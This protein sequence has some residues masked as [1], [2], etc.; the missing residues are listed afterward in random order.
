MAPLSQMD[1]TASFPQS[2]FNFL[3]SVFCNPGT[4]SMA[5]HSFAGQ[6]IL[7][8]TGRLAEPALRRLVP[9]LE[10]RFDVRLTIQVLPI[11]VAALMSPEWIAR[12]LLV[13]E[14]CDLVVLPGYCAKQTA[15]LSPLHKVTDKPILLG[16]R[17][18]RRLPEFFGGT[19]DPPALDKYSIQIIAE[20]NHAP[21]LTIDQLVEQ[22]LRLKEEGANIID[23][24][25]Q[26]GMVWNEVG[27]A[28]RE[29]VDRGVA[30]SIDS[31]NPQ[32]IAPAA[33][34]GASLV[35]SVNSTNRQAA[36]DWGCEV[37]AIPDNP[38][39]WL[40]VAETVDFLSAANVPFRIDPIIEPIG[41]GF[42]A[43][44]SRYMQARKIWPE[45]AM[46]MGIGNLSE[47]TD[48][49]SA[50]VNFLLLAI[51]EELQIHS[52]LTTQVINWARSSVRECDIARRIVHHSLS[53]QVPPKNLSTE[54]VCLR[55][56]RLTPANPE[57]IEILAQ[58]I[59]DNNYRIVAD[60]NMIHLLGSGQHWQHQDAFELFHQLMESEPTNVDPSHAFYLGYEMCKATIANQLGKNYEQD[61]SLNWGH[62]TVHEASH[63]R[64]KR[65]RKPHR[66]TDS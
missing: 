18:M 24:G 50:G 2:H 17:D 3:I 20:I 60:Q 55:D 6:S 54:L 48:V 63:R 21:Q 61:E 53:E 9:E 58:E 45:A 43:S 44:L 27:T 25:C 64:L 38:G 10:S 22:A 16:P 26:P 30:V 34:N 51:C 31:L 33:E 7:M 65:Q 57:D 56:P 23:I 39:D 13:P 28:V 37:I 15:Q 29:L 62:L 14:D 19:L 8:V 66:S 36:P 1:S 32:E 35:L 59:R 11:T 47:L 52:V 46:M 5:N 49:D 40:Q 12:H 41:F 4:T 42:A